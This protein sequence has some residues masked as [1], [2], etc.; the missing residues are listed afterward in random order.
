M[1]KITLSVV[2]YTPCLNKTTMKTNKKQINSSAQ[3]SFLN[4][5][6]PEQILVADGESG[7][8]ESLVVVDFNVD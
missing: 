3:L 2:V 7:E 6:L 1:S 8:L 5:P 4:N